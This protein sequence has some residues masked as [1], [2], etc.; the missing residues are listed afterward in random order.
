MN[1]LSHGATEEVC[2]FIDNE[3]KERQQGVLER[4][5]KISRSL[6]RIRLHANL[7]WQEIQDEI[8]KL[9]LVPGEDPDIYVENKL[10]QFETFTSENTDD[11][12]EVERLAEILEGPYSLCLKNAASFYEKHME[13]LH[14]LELEL[15]DPDVMEKGLPALFENELF[16]LSLCEHRQQ[17]ILSFH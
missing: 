2:E 1:L 4:L 13:T 15:I 14:K 8:G 11:E 9:D 12:L 17:S 3:I 6:G 10:K 16:R 7:R 5:G